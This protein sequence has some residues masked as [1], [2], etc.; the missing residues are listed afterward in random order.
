LF[1]PS[2]L[3]K[4]LFCVFFLFYGGGA[5]SLFFFP[6][7]R[8]VIYREHSVLLFF[9][10][11]SPPSLSS[12]PPSFGAPHLLTLPL[13]GDSDLFPPYQR[14]NLRAG[15]FPPPFSPLDKKICL[16][17]LSEVTPSPSGSRSFFLFCEKKRRA[18]GLPVFYLFGRDS[19]PYML[20]PLGARRSLSPAK[21]LP[22][23]NFTFLFLR[24][25]EP[26]CRGFFFLTPFP[27]EFS[28]FPP[29]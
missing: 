9:F 22:D 2:F 27:G 6:L 13:C 24:D 20:K 4:G 29:S 5:W 8:M 10:L 1:P 11:R 16:I 18:D 19:L 17:F 28:F 23:L 21:E 7:K 26:P 25:V 12:R 3:W 14:R 15:A